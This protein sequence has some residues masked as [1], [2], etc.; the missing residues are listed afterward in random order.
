[1]KQLSNTLLTLLLLGTLAWSPMRLS[2][3]ET[4]TSRS[5]NDFTTTMAVMG[6]VLSLSL[7]HI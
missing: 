3:Q 4:S 5:A 7:I 2:A 1:M 6:S